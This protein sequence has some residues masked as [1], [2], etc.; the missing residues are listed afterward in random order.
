MVLEKDNKNPFS[1]P[2]SWIRKAYYNAIMKVLKIN[3]KPKAIQEKIIKEI[4]DVEGSNVDVDK[5]KQWVYATQ[6]KK[7][8]EEIE[9]KS[10]K[11]L[12]ERE[13]EFV[14]RTKQEAKEQEERFKKYDKKLAVSE[15]FSHLKEAVATI[16]AYRD[17]LDLAN[18]FWKI[19]PYF[20]NNE[21][22][23]WLWNFEEYKW[24]LIDETDIMN[25]IDTALKQPYTIGSKVKAEIIEALKRV[26]R[27]R[28][29][30]EAPLRWIQFKN[31]AFS[32]RSNNIHDITPDFFFT[33]P[34]PWELGETSE[35]PIMDKLF[36]EWV[37]DV[38]VQDLYEIMAYCCY[39]NYPIQTLLCLY[40]FG[41]N[42]KSSFLNIM[43]KFL[44]EDNITSTELDLLVGHGSSRFE[45][46]K[47][48]KKL[49]CMLGETNFGVL[50]KSSILKKLVGG[51]KIGFE[52]KN[53]LPFTDFN[54]AKIIIASN[55]L[56]SSDDTSEGFYRRWHI[57]DFPNEFPEGKDI[58]LTIPN[59]EYRNLAR[60]VMEILPKLL[61]RGCFSNQGTIMERK[62]KYQMASNPL[63][64]F[65]KNC[66][67]RD[68]NEWIL[69]PDLFSAYCK[70]LQH[71]KRRM[72][73]RKEFNNVLDMEGL[74]PRRTTKYLKENPNDPLETT[75]TVNGYIIEGISLKI[76]W[77]DSILKMQIM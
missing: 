52:M 55:S 25:E 42:G 51:D 30:K 46:F 44:G 77:E 62:R 72:V 45:S 27:K 63:P 19:Q 18:Q 53:K 3:S 71:F 7:I 2:Q 75:G 5:L 32:L 26:G 37:G 10:E 40:G 56:P 8:I 14:R 76:D 66:C 22:M 20:Y 35:T 61:E 4:D 60:K 29:P 17:Y 68:L 64:Y 67:V 34:I 58:T 31:K 65:I 6:D 38:Y 70:F 73:S 69:H 43:D 36:R 54:Y 47:L 39:R 50:D 48:Y 13:K 59:I 11:L 41:R 49:C 12:E 1:T 21:K 24:E 74:T 15:D 33:N 23:W 9:K 28:M 57:I 16:T